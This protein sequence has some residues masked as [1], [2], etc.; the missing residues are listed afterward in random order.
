[1]I[2]WL[3]GGVQSRMRVVRMRRCRVSRAGSLIHHLPG[4]PVGCRFMIRALV[5]FV[6]LVASWGA[7]LPVGVS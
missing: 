3:G 6:L 4:V 7:A 2:G 1:M 5:L